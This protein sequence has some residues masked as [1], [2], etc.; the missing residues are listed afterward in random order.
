MGREF[1][2]PQTYY[3]F[4]SVLGE[5]TYDGVQL[6]TVN[7]HADSKVPVP[8][9]RITV[10]LD[11]RVIIAEHNCSTPGG[12]NYSFHQ[13]LKPSTAHCWHTVAAAGNVYRS[14]AT[15]QLTGRIS[16]RKAQMALLF[17]NTPTKISNFNAARL[18]AEDQKASRTETTRAN[19]GGR[20]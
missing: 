8:S 11:P 14:L 20:P 1:D 17:R 3:C 4:E 10:T 6:R 5:L 19:I 7:W 12:H 16:G 13:F 9:P 15:L 2:S 18:R